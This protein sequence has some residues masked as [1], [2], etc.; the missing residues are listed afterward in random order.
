[1][2]RKLLIPLLV[3]TLSSCSTYSSSFGCGDALGANCQPISVVDQMI[4]NGEILE[5]HHKKCRH[6]KC[7]TISMPELNNKEAPIEYITE[8]K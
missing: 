4:D 8:T 1:M 5:L 2:V 7:K 3:I 6:R